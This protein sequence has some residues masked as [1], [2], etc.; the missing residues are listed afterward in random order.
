MLRLGRN[1]LSGLFGDPEALEAAGVAV[2]RFRGCAFLRHLASLEAR[3]PLSYV[4][5]H[6]NR[7]HAA[8][9]PLLETH[10]G[11]KVSRTSFRFCGASDTAVGISIPNDKRF[12]SRLDSRFCSCNRWLESGFERKIASV[13]E[14]AWCIV[15]VELE[16]QELEDMRTAPL[17]PARRRLALGRCRHPLWVSE[18]QF[19]SAQRPIRQS[20]SI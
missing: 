2:K 9:D 4:Y 14:D 13:S 18:L 15:A 6:L 20:K 17:R 11:R 16:E 10:N 19:Q 5:D 7:I 1:L 8:H 12:T 3:A